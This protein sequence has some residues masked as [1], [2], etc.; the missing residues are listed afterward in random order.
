MKDK[1]LN[2]S[3]HT[4]WYYSIL[5]NNFKVYKVT[6]THISPCWDSPDRGLDKMVVLSE[7]LI[8][9][10]TCPVLQVCGHGH[11]MSWWLP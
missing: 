6:H 5:L 8:W 9:L 11:L 10:T 2:I 3:I 4:T 1:N 7:S